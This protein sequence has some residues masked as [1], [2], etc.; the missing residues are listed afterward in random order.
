MKQTNYKLTLSYDGT[1]FKG[2]QKQPGTEADTIQG[3]LEAIASKLN[4]RETAV[5]GAGRT[6]AGVHA[7]CQTANVILD[8][9]R[10]AAE[11]AELFNRYLPETVSVDR[12]EVCAPDFHARLSKSRKTYTYYVYL[13]EKPPVFRRKYVYAYGKPLDINKIKKACEKLEGVH[14]FRG[15]ATAVPKKKSSVRIIFEARAQIEGDTLTV[16]LTADGFLY[17]EVR[18]IVGTL[19]SIGCGELDENA[20]NRVFESGDRSEAGFTAPSRGLFLTDVS[21]GE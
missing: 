4:G 10:T 14:D 11:V 2:W 8:G 3:R 19:L 18:I 17:N 7:T 21:Y 1:G 16:K 20:V 9:E 6:D 12:A 5:N 15:F 13:S